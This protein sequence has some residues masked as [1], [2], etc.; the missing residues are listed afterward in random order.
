MDEYQAAMQNPTRNN[1]T[2]RLRQGD[3][4]AERM[5]A[6]DEID[7]LRIALSLVKSRLSPVYDQGLYDLIADVLPVTK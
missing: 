1:L 6:A 3:G 4:I 7:Q 5:E 2:T